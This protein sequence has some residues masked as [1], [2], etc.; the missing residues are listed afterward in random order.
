MTGYLPEFI[1]KMKDYAVLGLYPEQI[2]ERMNLIGEER[3]KFLRD[4][5]DIEHPLCKEYWKSR[6]NH[7]EDLAAALS[8]A[9]LSGDPKALD[10]AYELEHVKKVESL[11]KELFGI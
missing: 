11:K 2:A 4:I 10:L 3:R 5:T 1:S 7:E 6:S 8:S 9:A